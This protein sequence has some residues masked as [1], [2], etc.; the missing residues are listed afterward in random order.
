MNDIEKQLLSQSRPLLERFCASLSK[1]SPVGAAVTVAAAIAP[2][3]IYAVTAEVMQYQDILST[4]GPEALKA[5][6]AQLPDTAIAFATQAITGSL[7][8]Q[9]QNL[10]AFGLMAEATLPALT[11][12]SV[13]L[14]NSFVSL[15]RQVENLKVEN[16]LL[17]SGKPLPNA[18]VDPNRPSGATRIQN[19]DS[20]PPSKRFE[21]GLDALTTKVAAFQSE[22][23]PERSKGPRL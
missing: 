12:L 5:F 18:Q 19:V 17:S 11:G 4:Q 10:K 1:I 2:V 9:W 14:A 15:K 20:T 7:P 23:A 22:T 6:Q 8:H 13:Y 16:S 3:V 21:K